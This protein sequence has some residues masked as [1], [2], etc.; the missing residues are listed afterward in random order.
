MCWRAASKTAWS[1]AREC[2]AMHKRS[3]FLVLLTATLLAACTTTAT[4]PQDSGVDVPMA[5][6]RLDADPARPS[7][8]LAVDASAAV[9]HEWW[10][11]FGDPT[12]DTLIS[13]ALANN[14]S[15]Q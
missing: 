1:Q 11:H 7:A 12:L 9:E 5:W 6:A 15:L 14:K 10:T 3:S 8:P 4:V 2:P 13:E